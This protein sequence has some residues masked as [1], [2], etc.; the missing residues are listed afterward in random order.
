MELKLSLRDFGGVA[1]AAF[2]GD[3][4]GH[5]SKRRDDYAGF[6]LVAGEMNFCRGIRIGTDSDAFP[7][8][9]LARRTGDR[10][11]HLATFVRC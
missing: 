10:N 9:Y 3:R 4:S 6:A 1:T 5:L 2:P 11:Q 7:I 8:L